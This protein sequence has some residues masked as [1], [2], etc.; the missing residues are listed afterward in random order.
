MAKNEFQMDPRDKREQ[1]K[2]GLLVAVVLCGIGAIRSWAS[3]ELAIGLFSM[4]LVFLALAVACPRALGPVLF[5]WMKIAAALNWVMT[6][7]LLSLT[8]V[9][10]ITPFGLVIRLFGRDPLKR[11]RMPEAQTYWEDAEEQPTE[12]RRYFD[13]Y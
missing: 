12:F 6:R 11:K 5:V 13:Q 8:F 4:A 10:L 2:F 3:H 1:R 7:L 9:L